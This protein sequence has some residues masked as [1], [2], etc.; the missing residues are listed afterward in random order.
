[1][2]WLGQLVVQFYE[3]LGGRDSRFLVGLPL[4]SFDLT[5]VMEL[6]VYLLPLA[7]LAC[8]SVD[9]GRV[10]SLGSRVRG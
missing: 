5:Q 6:L 8:G 10:P 1:M 4:E 9:V 2:Q 3:G 7:L